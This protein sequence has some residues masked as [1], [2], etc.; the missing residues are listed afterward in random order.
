[1]LKIDDSSMWTSER[2]FLG[3]VYYLKYA[4]IVKSYLIACCWS[5][6]LRKI[7]WPKSQEVTRRLGSFLSDFKATTE[8]LPYKT[9]SNNSQYN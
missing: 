5:N 6:K 8:E 7:C 3:F 1:M 9:V 2:A 4:F